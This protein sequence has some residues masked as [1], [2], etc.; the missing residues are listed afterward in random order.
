MKTAKRRWSTLALL[1]CLALSPAWAAKKEKSDPDKMEYRRKMD[2][3]HDCLVV[4]PVFVDRTTV[5]PGQVLRAS[6]LL[7]N[8]SAADLTVPA[9]PDEAPDRTPTLGKEIWY[10][11]RCAR[12][13]TATERNASKDGRTRLGERA[14]QVRQVKAGETIEL[15]CPEVLVDPAKQK[16]ANDNYEISVDFVNEDG[17]VVATGSQRIRVQI[18]DPSESSTP[19]ARHAAILG[20]FWLPNFELLALKL[21][22]TTVRRGEV[23]MAK[24]A[25][26]NV[27]GPVELPYDALGLT[28]Y[29]EN[30][31]SEQWLFGKCVYVRA[32]DR[33]RIPGGGVYLKTENPNP[34]LETGHYLDGFG[35]QL[36]TFRRKDKTGFAPGEE[37]EFTKKIDSA[38]LEPG[39]YEIR[40]MIGAPSIGDIGVRRQFL[41]VTP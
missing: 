4:A 34:S 32:R 39:T 33:A 21:S 35:G 30:F 6:S 3:L 15:E 11:K 9:N 18:Q 2:E 23:V 5:R 20:K 26:K 1:F 7:V 17:H 25:L 37:L 41:T 16:L 24:C 28:P 40:L 19:A 27:S 13:P 14:H 8:T 36:L 38:K 10:L 29:K 31:G 22:A 12:N